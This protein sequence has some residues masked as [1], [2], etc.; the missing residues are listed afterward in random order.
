MKF[1]IK[2]CCCVTLCVGS[3]KDFCFFPS[4]CPAFVSVLVCCLLRFELVCFSRLWSVGVFL[5]DVTGLS[6][7]FFLCLGVCVSPMYVT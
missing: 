1:V 6:F 5:C 4:V 7:R 2:S 3:C